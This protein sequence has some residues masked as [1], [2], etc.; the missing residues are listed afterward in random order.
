MAMDAVDAGLSRVV[1]SRL[2]Q[3]PGTRSHH[4]CQSCILCMHQWAALTA[5]A[6]NMVMAVLLLAFWPEVQ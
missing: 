2:M 4:P 6:A 5:K 1:A 3:V